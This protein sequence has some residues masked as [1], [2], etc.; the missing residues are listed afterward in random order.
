MTKTLLKIADDIQEAYRYQGGQ[1]FANRIREASKDARAAAF[2]EAA[3]V[4]DKHASGFP[5]TSGSD[6]EVI[7]RLIRE[8]SGRV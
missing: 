2:E 4:A 1:E 8:Q 6:A 7:A 3:K 5:W